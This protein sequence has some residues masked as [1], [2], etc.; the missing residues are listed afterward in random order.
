MSYFLFV[1]LRSFFLCYPGE[2]LEGP[3]STEV[4]SKLNNIDSN[5]GILISKKY[6][7]MYIYIIYTQ[8]CIFIYELM[9]YCKVEILLIVYINIYVHV[10]ILNIIINQAILI[11]TY[12]A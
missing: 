8:I 3:I 11:S 10:F 2:A 4:S 12:D 9:L 1:P 5:N 7:T 6:Y